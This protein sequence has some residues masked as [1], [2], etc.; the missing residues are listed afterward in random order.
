[1]IGTQA[2]CS[3]LPNYIGQS[4]NCRPECTINAECSSN[5]ACISEKCQNP[6]INSCGINARCSVI[7]H[8]AVCTCVDGYEGD[9]T[10]QCVLIPPPRKTFPLFKISSDL[11]LQHFYQQL[12][13][14]PFRHRAIHRHAVRTQNAAKTTELAPASALMDTKATHSILSVD[15]VANVKPTRIAYRILHA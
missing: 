13:V 2:A 9:P 15:V 12:S 14:H 3:C 8:N 7:N 1:M 5:L 4:P 10:S 11:F 6:C